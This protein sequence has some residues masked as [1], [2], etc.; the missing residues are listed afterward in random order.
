MHEADGKDYYFISADEF[1]SRI[2]RNDF[3]EWQEVYPDQYYGTLKSEIER[4]WD[5]GDNVIFDVDVVGGLNLKKIF[6]ENSLAVFVEPP[7]METLLSRLRNRST[8][9]ADKIAI[10]INKATQE[11]TYAPLFDWVLINDDLQTAL[12]EAEH[13]VADFLGL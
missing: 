12:V 8:E 5:R 13:K 6:R 1:R 4:I 10:R 3:L 7:S 9:T 2:D 11:M